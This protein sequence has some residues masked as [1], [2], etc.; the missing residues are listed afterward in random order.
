MRLTSLPDVITSSSPTPTVGMAAASDLDAG[1]TVSV[2]NFEGLN[3]RGFSIVV[4]K[5]NFVVFV[6]AIAI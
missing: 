2:E 3:F 4:Q 6:V 5:L 1:L